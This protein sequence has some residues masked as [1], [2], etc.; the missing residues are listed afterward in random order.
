MCRTEFKLSINHLNKFNKSSKCY[1][2][3]SGTDK[4]CTKII[5]EKLY[6]NRI[7]YAIIY[8]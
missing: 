2:S 3:D 7:F 1:L 6:Q 8:K 4:F 5:Q